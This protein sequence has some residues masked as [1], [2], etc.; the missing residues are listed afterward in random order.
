MTEAELKSQFQ[1]I[2]DNLNESYEKND[3]E[4]ISKLL[5]D[6]WIILEP[7]TG[8]SDKEQFLQAI[9]DGRLKHSSM[10]KEVL[11]VKSYNDFTIV[12]TRGKNKGNYLAEPFNAEQWVTNI[13]KKINSHWICVMTQ[14]APVTC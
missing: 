7:S 1:I 13:Y 12:I 4:K 11:Q 8:L 14:E 3:T 5:S 10:K 6:D 2:E 9:R